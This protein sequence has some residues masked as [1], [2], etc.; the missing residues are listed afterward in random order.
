MVERDCYGCEGLCKGR[1]WPPFVCICSPFILLYNSIAIYFVPCVGIF[2][3]RLLRSFCFCLCHL[4]GC[5]EYRDESF[6]GEKAIGDVPGHKDSD[7]LKAEQLDRIGSSKD[8]P[9]M[10]LF[11][12]KIEPKDVAQGAVGDCWLIAAFAC[13]AEFPGAIQKVFVTKEWNTRGKYQL[14][15]YDGFQERWETV[16]IDDRIPCK[17]GT[18]Q[19]AFSQPNGNE[20]W[21]ILLEKAF[22]KFCGSYGALD[23]GHTVWAW[24]AMTGD[25]VLFFKLVPATKR[26]A[27]MDVSYPTGVRTRGKREIGFKQTEEDYDEEKIWKMLR[28]YDELKSVLAASITGEGG[29]EKLDDVGLVKGHAYSILN[30]RKVIGFKLLKLRNPW[31]SFEW[32]GKWSDKCANWQR[33]PEVAKAVG[34]TAEDDGAFWME[35]SDFV[36]HYNRIQVCNRTT[37]EDLHLDVKE[38]SGFCGPAVGC[39]SGCLSFWCCCKGARVI[40]CG[41]KSS[42]KTIKTGSKFLPEFMDRE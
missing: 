37:D 1:A 35:Y 32:K 40:F 39:C 25:N 12:G 31:G 21:V 16:T 22:A 42:E 18:T 27:R 38:D 29:E 41:H 2:F 15:L 6:E 23:G 20:M 8:A 5:Y 24:Q 19:A 28:K 3:T 13:L 34:F 4:C 14:R 30:V 9:S 36:Q 7:F 26:W 33:Y 10:K 17:K 11:E